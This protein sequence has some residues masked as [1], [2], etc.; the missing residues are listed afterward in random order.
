M[1]A[2][3]AFDRAMGAN[4]E[5]APLNDWRQV[6]ATIHGD[7]LANGFNREV[8]AFPVLWWNHP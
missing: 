2:W 8:G 5:D 1:M 3:V 6:R 7:V 4:V